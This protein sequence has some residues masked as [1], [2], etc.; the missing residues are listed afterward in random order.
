M[1]YVEIDEKIIDKIEKITMAK[2]KRVG[3]LIPLEEIEDAFNDLLLEIDRIQEELDDEVEQRESY[4]KP[5]SHKEIEG[6]P[7]Y[8][9]I[10]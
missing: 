6:I 8:G 2:F 5:K 10:D 9:P 7:E 4:W 1:G 3:N